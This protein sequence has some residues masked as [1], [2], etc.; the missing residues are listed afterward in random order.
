[1][2]R[3]YPGVH[4]TRLFEV[5]AVLR[6]ETFRGNISVARAAGAVHDLGDLPIEL[7]PSHPS[8]RASA[9]GSY[10]RTSRWPTPLFVA[11]AEELGEPRATKD[12]GLA[13]AAAT[14]GTAEVT[15]LG[16]GR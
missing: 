15:R 9:C 1:M 13:A 16:H 14:H 2:E 6:R 11:L 5:L 4:H 12:G 10:V 8:P 3:W 7:A